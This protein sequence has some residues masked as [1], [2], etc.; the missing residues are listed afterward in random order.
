MREICITEELDGSASADMYKETVELVLRL[1]GKTKK[2]LIV[3]VD[4]ARG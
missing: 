4:S 3:H 2:H 1:F